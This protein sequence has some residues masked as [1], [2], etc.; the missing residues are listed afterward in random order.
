MARFDI[1]YHELDI[2]ILYVQRGS[3]HLVPSFVDFLDVLGYS[4]MFWVL[5]TRLFSE[6]YRIVSRTSKFI[7]QEPPEQFRKIFKVR[8]CGRN[9]QNGS[10]RAW[11]VHKDSG[12]VG[13]CFGCIPECIGM[14]WNV[15]EC[16]ATG[17]G[18]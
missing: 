11:K 6:T 8:A 18:R 1:N 13:E 15:L 16:S 10:G 9:V 3:T 7:L 5:S 2:C 14:F 12:K 17:C 4:E